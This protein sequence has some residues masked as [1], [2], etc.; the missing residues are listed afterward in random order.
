M[1]DKLK[2][3]LMK[4]QGSTEYMV[5]LALVLTIVLITLTILGFFSGFQEDARLGESQDYWANA[6]QPI[7]I[8]DWKLVSSPPKLFLVVQDRAGSMLNLTSIN[9]TSRDLGL[10]TPVGTPTALQ[11]GQVANVTFNVNAS[12]QQNEAYEF[13]LVIY[14]GTQT[15]GG[16]EQKGVKP[17]IVRCTQ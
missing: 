2:A 3:D 16:L 12:C 14:Y 17:L 8:V 6:A 11:P 5:I 1:P 10:N 4:A 7:S 15:V 9:M 13:E